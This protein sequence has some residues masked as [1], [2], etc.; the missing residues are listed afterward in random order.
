MEARMKN[1]LQS[2]LFVATTAGVVA[3]TA[4]ATQPQNPPTNPW[5]H[6]CGMGPWP[7]G[8]GMTG[9]SGHGMMGR[10]GHGMMVPANASMARNHAAMMGGVPAPYT[11]LSNPLP[12][13]RA[14]VERGARVYAANC[15][16]C[17]GETGLGDGPAG[18]GLNPPP[19]NLTWLS[20]MPMANWDPFMIWTVQ[21][22]GAAYNTAMPA[23]K[24]TLSRYDAWAVIAYI[25]ARL[26]PVTAN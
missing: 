9:P 24:D 25:Q 8:P 4:A 1:F 16:S 20:R 6:C 3:A 13:T 22:G 11:T 5:S 23:F 14:T 26:P 2:L 19:V 17:H 10:G 12:R 7:Q 18:R 15:A 21:E